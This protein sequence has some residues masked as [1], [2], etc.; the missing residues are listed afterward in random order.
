MVCRLFLHID[1][2]SWYNRD[3]GIAS[4]WM[5]IVLTVVHV[6][7]TGFFFFSEVLPASRTVRK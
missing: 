2:C 1:I 6:Q 3:P 4:L 5:L 7:M